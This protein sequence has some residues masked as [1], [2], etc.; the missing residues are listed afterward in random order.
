[1]RPNGRFD[2][3]SVVDAAW[4]FTFLARST[5]ELHV[6]RRCNGRLLYR[7]RR[8]SARSGSPPVFRLPAIVLL[9][10]FGLL[11]GPVLQVFEPAVV[12]GAGLRPVVGLAVA[13]VVFE[14]GLALD[15]REL[16]A[17]GGGIVRLTVVALPISF[18]LASAAAHF[19]ARIPWS[20]ALL[21]GAITVV[22][23]PTVVLP[24]LRN[25][26]LQTR[27]ASFFKWEAIV[28]DPVGALMAAVVLAVIIA[29]GH[30]GTS[31]VVEVVAGLLAA[32]I[33]GIGA[34]LLFRYLI[35]RDLVQES[36]KTPM[37]LAF[38]LGVYVLSNLVMAESGL[39]AATILGIA[40]ANLK[41]R[42]LSELTRIKESL[43]VLIV[44]ALFVVLTAN[45]ERSLF[46]QLS[47]ST[48]LLTAAMILVVRPLTI[49]MATLGSDLTLRETPSDRMDRAARDRGGRR[50]E[51]GRR[52]AL[53]RRLPRRR[54]R[55]A[56]GLH[57]HRLDHGATRPLARTD[58]AEAPPDPGRQ[59]DASHHR[60]DA[61]D[62]DPGADP[63]PRRDPPSC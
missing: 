62:R 34:A 54:T 49:A 21:Y 52:Q 46:V 53:R 30:A 38:A 9:F 41:I 8:G 42:G 24:L 43:V 58:R 17:A 12:F 10:A 31:L 56:C 55:D 14:G 16:R 20:P 35:Q 23:G 5:E 18:G 19:I 2:G 45:L 15:F 60:C 32:G 3:R 44:S 29:G 40:L 47:W 39:G 59:A 63:R 1:M 25:T 37:L 33:L 11:I 28:N 7:D 57:A 50:G 27:V 4:I 36:L 61:L 26:R 51:R 48:Y 22:T 13:I 6:P